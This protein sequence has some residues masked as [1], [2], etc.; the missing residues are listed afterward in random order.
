MT[1]LEHLQKRGEKRGKKLGQHLGQVATLTRQ[2]AAAASQIAQA[3]LVSLARAA[4]ALAAGERAVAAVDL[5][6]DVGQQVRQPCEGQLISLQ[7]CSDGT[8]AGILE[9]YDI[10]GREL[11]VNVSS[12]TAITDA[13]LDA[14]IAAGRG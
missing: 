12:A 2:M 6:E 8:N 10:S 14:A 13:V 7:V 11:G 5:V 9:L 1:L 3:D 4:E